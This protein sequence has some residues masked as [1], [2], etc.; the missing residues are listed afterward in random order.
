MRSH[1]LSLSVLLVACSDYNLTPDDK[2]NGE[3]DTS[4]PFGED[5]GSDGGEISACGN[6]DDPGVSEAPINTE[7]EVE[8]QNGTFTPV[9]EWTY[10]GTGSFYGP[11]VAG[12]VVDSNGNGRVDADDRVLIFMY[13]NTQVV[14]LFGDNGQTAWTSGFGYGQDGGMALGDV[15]GDGAPDLITAY[16][17]SV[18]ALDARTGTQKWCRAGLGATMDA[19]G[20]N[21]PSI[22][23]MNGDGAAEVTIGGSILRGADG[24][25]LAQGGLGIGMAPYGG[26]P[27]WG[28]GTL[29]VPVDLDNDGQMEL[30]T[31]NTAYNFDGSIKWH[32]GGLDGLVAVADFDGDGE[33]EIIKTSGIYVYGMETDGT[34][35]WG[36]LTYT[37]VNI[38]PAAID[39]LNGD[40]TP[41]FVFAAGNQLY[42]MRWGG[43]IYWQQTIA[44]FSGA[45]G[46]S[47]FDFEMDGYPEVLYAD[48]TSIRF[49]SGLD[50]SQK[51][52][53]FEHGSWT[54]LETPIVADVDGDD[55]VEIVLGHGAYNRSL[56]VFG[57]ADQSW[58]PGR[59]VWNQHAYQISN[60]NDDL[61]VTGGSRNNFSLYNS[62][63]SG[64]IGRPP[65]EYWDLT[66]E[67]L[68]VCEDECTAGRLYVAAR[69][70]NN[71]NIVVPAG[72]PV[73]LRAGAGGPIVAAVPTTREIAP[74]TTGE[75]L[76]YE[77]AADQ[78][79]GTVPIV[80]A[81]EALDGLNTLFECEEINNAAAWTREV[82]RGD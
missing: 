74:G 70:V 22:A 17:D 18:C 14:A 24:L 64:D 37:G 32:N 12:P 23:D 13:Q 6:P 43:T 21:Y 46:P 81:D 47:L 66:A 49:Y 11:A 39:D 62:F 61:S 4:D 56:T 71:G 55:Q 77:V 2:T 54:I 30:V 19:Y 31:G 28:Y 34:E 3:A 72:V 79:A 44:D 65:S 51:Y 5:G 29:S 42:A 1:L 68:D 15:D 67:I 8:L 58:P 59:T 26:T 9:V 38:G 63:R 7:C 52:S 20:Y 76:L 80:T 16:I 73:S 53:S 82:C 45:A 57:D 10:G 33:G 69:V 40:G 78:M 35:V 36:P 75:L 25:V 48:E 60:V 41:E 27:G 50:G